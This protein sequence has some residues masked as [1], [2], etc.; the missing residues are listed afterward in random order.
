MTHSEMIK[1]GLNDWAGYFRRKLTDNVA[2]MYFAKIEPFT[3]KPIKLMF[4]TAMQEFEPKP[5]NFP[6]FRY[7]QQFLG[8]IEERK[9]DYDPEE[10]QR[11][12]VGKLWEGYRILEKHGKDAFYSYCNSVGMP[13]NDRER[14]IAKKEMSYNIND[15]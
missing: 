7:I 6:S 4:E 2:N 11:F 3:E 1:S 9:I 5:S 10:D 13:L 12:P 15:L 14:V 8:S